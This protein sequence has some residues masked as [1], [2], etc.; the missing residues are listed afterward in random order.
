MNGSHLDFA[1]QT[2]SVDIGRPQ[3]IVTMNSGR[4]KL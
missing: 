2:K 3:T 1:V 4:N